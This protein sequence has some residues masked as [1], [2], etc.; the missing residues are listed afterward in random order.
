MNIVDIINKKRLKKELNYKELEFVINGYINSDI[1]SYQLSALLMAMNINGMSGIE[2]I[3]FT[4]LLI[5]NKNNLKLNEIVVTY[6]T[7]GG[8]ENKTSLI[9]I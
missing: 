6:D 4:E 1:K 2:T 9:L 7:I 8:I 5:K 3:N